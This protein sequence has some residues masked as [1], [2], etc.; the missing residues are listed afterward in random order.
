MKRT[1]F[2]LLILNYSLSYCQK[3]CGFKIDEKKII[4]NENLDLFLHKLK[5]EKF[6]IK[7]RK[8]NIPTQILKQL[9]CLNG[10][11]TIANPNEKSQDGDIFDESEKLPIRKLQFLALNDK[12][13]ILVY[14]IVSGPGISQRFM[15]IDYNS[16]GIRDFWCGN[17]VRSVYEIEQL[18][19]LIENHKNKP[20]PLGLQSN[21]FY[22]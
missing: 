6:E 21:L 10:E 16:K 14:K 20:F 18:I 9:E 13:I 3:D 19:S 7:Y 8:E 17:G 22:F 11:F 2:I 5:Q 15:F 1:F 4:K 12:T